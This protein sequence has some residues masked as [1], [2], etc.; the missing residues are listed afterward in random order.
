[1]NALKIDRSFVSDIPQ[2]QDD[3]SITAAVI[4]LCR[5]L[6]IEA[7]AEGV[8]TLEQL[9]FL[10]QQGCDLGQGFLLS[11]PIPATEVIP[12]AR[13]QQVVDTGCY[14]NAEAETA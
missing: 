5:R 13:A 11:R 8:E 14:W 3:A 6:G 2:D 12:W 10:R 1:V 4:V 9:E 7:I